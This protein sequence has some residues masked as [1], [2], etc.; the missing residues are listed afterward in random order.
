MIVG[1]EEIPDLLNGQ[2]LYV[3]IM[4]DGFSPG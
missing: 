2:I 3:E 1:A 4:P